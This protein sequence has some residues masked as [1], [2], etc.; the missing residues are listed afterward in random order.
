MD[1]LDNG[2]NHK[3][4][5]PMS[6]LPKKRLVLALFPTAEAARAAADALKRSRLVEGRAMGVFALDDGKLRVAKVGGRSW[7]AGGLIGAGALILGPAMIGPGIVVGT[8][9]GGLHRK[10]LGISMADRE[11]LAGELQGGK[12][13]LGIKVY[14]Q[15]W[16]KTMVEVEKL[17][18][19]P[20]SYEVAAEVVEAANKAVADA[21]EAADD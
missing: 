3:T 21:K 4:G 14:E 20:E 1:V 8:L 19:R 16:A 7:G 6:S 17:G 18:G 2:G 11:R 12:A 5:E 10:D 9:A 15:D 13:A